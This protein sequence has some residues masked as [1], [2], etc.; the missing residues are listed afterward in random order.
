MGTEGCSY[1]DFISALSAL[2]RS[3]EATAP[4][5]Q[6]L[7]FTIGEALNQ[8]RPVADEEIVKPKQKRVFKI[9]EEKPK[10]EE[11]TYKSDMANSI[12]KQAWDFSPIFDF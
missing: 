4:K 1:E 2:A 3:V 9:L 7:A 10:P 11:E 6:E 5:F 8:S 12:I